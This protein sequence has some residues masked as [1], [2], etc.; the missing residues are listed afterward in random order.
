MMYI[1]YSINYTCNDIAYLYK[2]LNT[3]KAVHDCA[4]NDRG[5]SEARAH[6]SGSMIKKLTI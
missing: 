6:A 1:Q 4:A 5:S 3:S 2:I